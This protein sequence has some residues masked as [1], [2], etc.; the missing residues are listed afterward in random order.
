MIFG[1]PDILNALL[2][3][4]TAKYG[5]ALVSATGSR[6]LG[7]R[8]E[9]AF[10]RIVDSA[11]EKS[12]DSAGK[13]LTS[14]QRKQLAKIIREHR[15]GIS[16]VGD[17]AKI[18]DLVHH[19]IGTIAELDPLRVDRSYLADTLA[20]WITDGVARDAISG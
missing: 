5:D 1:S 14:G 19:L 12:V 20:F 9:R 11:I 4:L 10:G 18:G 3:W 6:I 7:S 2:G 15:P 13:S 8:Q 16:D 17:F